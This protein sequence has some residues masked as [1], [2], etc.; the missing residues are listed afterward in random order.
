MVLDVEEEYS[1]LPLEFRNRVETAR[2]EVAEARKI[3]DKARLA[4]ALNRLGN[5]ER[6]PRLLHDV[7]LATFA[8]AREL[9]HELGM[10]LDEG[11]VQRQ[12]G[13]VQEY[14]GRLTKAEESY[15]NALVLYRAY[16]SGK[17]LDYANAVRYVAVIKN[18]VGKRDESTQLWLEAFGRYDDLNMPVPVA[19]AAAWQTIFALERNELDA[20]KEWFA[21][22]DAA[23]TAANDPDTDKF[24]SEV[25]SRLL[26]L[27]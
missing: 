12:I 20:A 3:G 26:P 13:I 18:R 25:K 8:E 23:A 24:I 11:G 21:K 10:P 16:E 1:N 27:N 7:A 4:H 14:Q 2:R 17:T 15:E 5:I 22:A 6:R 19:E 9:F